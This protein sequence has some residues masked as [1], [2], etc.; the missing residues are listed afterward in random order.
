MVLCAPDPGAE[1]VV[2]MLKTRGSMMESST[3]VDGGDEAPGN[4][5]DGSGTASGK[6]DASGDEALGDA[7]GGD[8][9]GGG[10]DDA[11][12]EGGGEGEVVILP[13]GPSC[14]DI[15]KPAKR[16][17]MP[18]PASAFPTPRPTYS[19]GSAAGALRREDLL[20]ASSAGDGT[21]GANDSTTCSPNLPAL[22]TVV[23]TTDEGTAAARVARVT[24]ARTIAKPP[25]IY[26]RIPESRR[27]RTTSAAAE[28]LA[29]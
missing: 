9:G 26:L 2:E 29:R 3:G 13:G 19:T 4:G 20:D 10:G 28:E 27:G 16:S 12:D 23:I 15:A 17:H 5:V 6:G 7:D 21:L 8:G 24:R 25:K 11:G 14:V 1:E 18:P 22:A